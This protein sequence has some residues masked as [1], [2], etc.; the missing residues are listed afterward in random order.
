MI[1]LIGKSIIAI[2]GICPDKRVKRSR[3][4]YIMFDDGETYIELEDQDHYTF[5]DFATSAK[6]IRVYHNKHQW[7]DIIG[8]LR[9][10]PNATDELL[11][12][13]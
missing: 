12:D 1:S 7:E 11:F 10:Y 3:P 4:H 6:H 8:N 5:H 9:D 2:R 13:G